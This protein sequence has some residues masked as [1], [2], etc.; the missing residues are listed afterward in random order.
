MVRE[1]G[2]ERRETVRFLSFIKLRKK[3]KFYPSTRGP[4]ED[5]L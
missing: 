3:K 2:S 5:N 1:L 4:D